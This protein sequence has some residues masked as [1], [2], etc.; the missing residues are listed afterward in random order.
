[1]ERYYERK[2]VDCVRRFGV[3]YGIGSLCA[4][5][6][7]AV[8]LAAPNRW[9]ARFWMSIDEQ[10]RRGRLISKSAIRSLSE[11]PILNH[12]PRAKMIRHG[13]YFSVRFFDSRAIKMSG[14]AE[15]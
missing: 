15:D 8:A 4:G 11:I 10:A 9:T 3:A 1:M 12:H 2:Y 7:L 14:V 13:C 5:I 6:R